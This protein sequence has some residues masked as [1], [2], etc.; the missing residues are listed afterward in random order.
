VRPIVWTSKTLAAAVVERLPEPARVV[1]SAQEFLDAPRDART[2]SIIDGATLVELDALAASLGSPDDIL[3]RRKLVN[4]VALGPVIA[5]CA[6]RTGVAHLADH[7]WLCHLIS[8]DTLE[9]PMAGQHFR[10]LL[11]TF[12]GGAVPRLTDWMQAGRRIRLTHASSRAERLGR[13]CEFFTANGVAPTEIA[14]LRDTGDELLTNAFYNA[15][16]AAGA[17]AKPIPRAHDVALPED[18]ACELVYGS[19]AHLAIVR[20]RDPFGSL[21]RPR[22]LSAI[23]QGERSGL[24]RLIAN[25][26]L[27]GVSVV[28]DRHTEMLVGIAK[29]GRCVPF[30]LHLFFRGGPRRRVWKSLDGDTGL[31][32]DTV[33]VTVTEIAD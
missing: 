16:F 9:H 27:V 31:A 11:A 14:L 19:S 12:A 23:A 1:G 26:A 15:P 21:D 7:P 8:A 4:I 24:A 6:D 30:A 10:E 5:I 17:A 3:A 33:S 25:A 28:N 29:P 32:R 18:L 13:M 22:L 20:V 2:L